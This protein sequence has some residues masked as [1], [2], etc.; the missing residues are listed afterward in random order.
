MNWWSKSLQL[1]P[2]ALEYFGSLWG[3]DLG[4][5]SLKRVWHTKVIIINKHFVTA[6]HMPNAEIQLPHQRPFSC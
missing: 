3:L 5:F 2:K 6:S 1:P 4:Q